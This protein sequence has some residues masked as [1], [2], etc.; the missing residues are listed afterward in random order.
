MEISHLAPE[1]LHSLLEHD[2]RDAKGFAL[3][4]RISA[5]FVLSCFVE[6]RA[7]LSNWHGAA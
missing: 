7:G 2:T 6:K 4:P 5:N 3:I 1:M